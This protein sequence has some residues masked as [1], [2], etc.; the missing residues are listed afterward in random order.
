MNLRVKD[1]IEKLAELPEETTCDMCY[2][3]FEESDTYLRVDPDWS[4][5]KIE[6]ASEIIEKLK[7]F[8]EKAIMDMDIEDGFKYSRIVDIELI[9]PMVFDY[10]TEFERLIKQSKT[11]GE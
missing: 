7:T 11:K 1:L 6:T 10:I 4:S 5:S 2:N 3:F 9:R 8:N